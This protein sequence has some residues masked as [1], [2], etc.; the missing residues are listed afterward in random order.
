LELSGG[1]QAILKS[2]INFGG[3]LQSPGPSPASLRFKS[4][5][6]TTSIL[7][8]R[9]IQGLILE[10]LME[11]LLTTVNVFQTTFLRQTLQKVRTSIGLLLI[12][13][14]NTSAGVGLRNYFWTGEQRYK[15]FGQKKI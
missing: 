6:R 7:R 12:T 4:F 15:S 9:A 3:V 13:N 1:K 2:P 8:F 14:F 5:G 10:A 11:H